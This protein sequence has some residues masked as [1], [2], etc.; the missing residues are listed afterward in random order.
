MKH[1]IVAL[2]SLSLIVP[3]FSG[4]QTYAQ[5]GALGAGLGA[6]AGAA[7][8]STKGKALEGAII[9]AV[10][11]T[12]VGLVAHDIKARRAK[13]QEQT[14]I[15]YNYQPSQGE[16]LT[17]EE[18]S[19]LPPNARPGEMV[20][21]NAQYALLGAG[22]GVEV[23]ESRR[24]MRGG[25]TIAEVSSK[26]FTRTDGTWVSSQNIRLPSNLRPGEY[27]IRT[28][29]RTAKSGVSGSAAFVVR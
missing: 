8:G 16:M 2:L 29:V 12:V 27:S 25:E 18:A 17:W 6:G 24:L 4:C 1:A 9:G 20:E 7:I 23:T 13:S 28:E 19:V 22:G 3:L 10:V 11:G 14:A 15:D 26:T 21:A 5:G